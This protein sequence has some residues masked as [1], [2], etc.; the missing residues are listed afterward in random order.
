MMRGDVSFTFLDRIQ[1][2]E[3]NMKD[4]R[5]QS[6]LALALTLPD[7]CGGIAY[8]ELVKRYRDGRV[9][10]DRYG[11]PTRD[12]GTQYILW[13]DTYAA[14]F[15]LKTE[16]S[17]EPYI[18]GERCWQLRCEYLHQNK[19]F[20]NTNDDH[21]VHFHLGLNCGSSICHL[22][23]ESNDG[24]LSNIRLDIQQ[25]CS[26]LCMAARSYYDS[27]HQEKDFSL[28]NTPV[29]DF[30]KWQ[31]EKEDTR[32]NILILT[33]DELLGKGISL[34][35]ESPSIQTFICTSVSDVMR[36]TK[37]KRIDVWIV[38]SCFMKMDEGK[39][40][41]WETDSVLLLS[42]KYQDPEPSSRPW[43]NLSI[44]FSLDD[45]ADTVESCLLQ[46]GK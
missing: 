34:A 32:K 23:S 1:E 13:F 16:S 9:M 41:T 11:N 12:T 40:F 44:P 7:I 31:H 4:R 15:F 18:N 39:W 22:D 28:Y 10:T 21:E 19:G 37:K 27:Y 14:G 38:E 2:I 29:I 24:R 3:F 35:L 46:G 20:V 45:L 43:K 36:R 33:G 30:I 8:P 5:W 6:A 17:E 26:R 42:S 25:M